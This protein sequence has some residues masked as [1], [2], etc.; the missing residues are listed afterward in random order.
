MNLEIQLLLF[1]TAISR[2]VLH[3]CDFVCEFHG[4]PQPTSNLS[5]PPRRKVQ[6][7]LNIVDVKIP[8]TSLPIELVLDSALV[9][10]YLEIFAVS[11]YA[12]TTVQIAWLL[13]K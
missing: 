10:S 9:S 5:N 2:K 11:L 1:Q 6:L 3:L 4:R 8:K 12:N 13:H 7:Y